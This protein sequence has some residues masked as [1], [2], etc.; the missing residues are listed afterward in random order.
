MLDEKDENLFT[1]LRVMPVSPGIFILLR[2]IFIT[3]LG[4]FAS[5]FTIIFSGI[6]GINLYNSVLLSIQTGLFVPLITLFCITFGRN[7]VEGVTLVKGINFLSIIPLV[8]IFSAPDWEFMGGIIP[9]YWVYKAFERIEVFS[10]MWLFSTA[11]IGLNMLFISLLYK[12]FQA[13]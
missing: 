8:F 11:G 5:W 7:K 1:V 13:I 2:L 4:F 9:F 10:S 12:K 3:L 6:E